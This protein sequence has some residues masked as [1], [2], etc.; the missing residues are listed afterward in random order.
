MFTLVHVGILVTFTV[1]RHGYKTE[2]LAPGRLQSGRRCQRQTLGRGAT[3]AESAPC[4]E[5][6]DLC[7]RS[8]TVK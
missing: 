6:N 2:R 5:R 3:Q 7:G 8:E 1:T 4:A